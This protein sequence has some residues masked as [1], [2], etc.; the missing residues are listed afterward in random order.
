MA[1]QLVTFKDI[2]DSVLETANLNKSSSEA[3]N[4]TL[5]FINERYNDIAQMTRWRWLQ[6]S[7]STIVPQVYETGTVTINPL[8]A[9]LVGSGVSWAASV[10]GRKVLFTS[11]NELYTISSRSSATRVVLT[12]TYAGASLAAV[13]YRI[14]QDVITSATDCE[15]V[16][17]VYHFP[18]GIGRARVM[19][20]VSQRELLNVRMRN[21]MGDYFPAVWTHEN[22]TTTGTRK[23]GI[24][25]GSKTDAPYR[26]R[27]EYIQKVTS[28]SATGDVPLMPIT[29]RSALKWGALADIFVQQG[30]MQRAQWAEQKYMM[31]VQEM[32]KDYETTDRSIRFIAPNNRV[33]ERRI[34]PANFDLGSAWE[35]DTWNED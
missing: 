27:Y 31:K 24:W 7:S 9:T 23:I 29:Y 6:K 5:R 35:T 26:L 15:E 10:V 17:D 33:K 12:E 19:Q 16:I 13:E 11:V 32:K 3:S 2:R 18:P 20:P 28:L 4:M 25:P 22:S 30:N 1:Q 34:S 14:I 21:N 8:S